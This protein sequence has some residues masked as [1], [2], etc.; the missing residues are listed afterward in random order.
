MTDLREGLM[1]V[2]SD[3][4]M[5]VVGHLVHWILDCFSGYLSLSVTSGAFFYVSVMAICP[6][7]IIG[8]L[9][10]HHIK[11][12]WQ[13]CSTTCKLGLTFRII[14]NS[15]ICRYSSSSPSDKDITG[16]PMTINHDATF[17]YDNKP[18]R[19]NPIKD[20]H[21]DASYASRHCHSLLFQSTDSQDDVSMLDQN[22][23]A[24]RQGN[25]R[26]SFSWN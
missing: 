9:K 15:F 19:A 14:A 17:S 18:E 7:F 3:H 1:I 8:Y 11:L 20:E 25:Q 26:G 2:I 24:S 16:V 6:S 10:Y 4:C 23:V 5:F 22:L 21:C 13:V 12:P